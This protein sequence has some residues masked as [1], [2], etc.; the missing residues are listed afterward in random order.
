MTKLRANEAAAAGSQKIKKSPPIV[1]IL[2]NM[3]KKWNE[4]KLIIEMEFSILNSVNLRAK[5]LGSGGF[6]LLGSTFEELCCGF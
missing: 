1:L 4:Q 5:I 3:S 6:A 2:Q